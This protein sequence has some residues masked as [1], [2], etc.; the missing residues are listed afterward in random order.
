MAQAVSVATDCRVLYWLNETQ[1]KLIGKYRAAGSGKQS[2]FAP[3]LHGCLY[4]TSQLR[5]FT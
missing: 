3:S 4:I 1:N 2:W 5:A